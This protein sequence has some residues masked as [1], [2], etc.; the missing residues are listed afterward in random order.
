MT[1]EKY[2]VQFSEWMRWQEYPSHP[3]SKHPGVY[4][5]GRFDSFPPTLSC[6]DENIIYIGE[7]VNQTLKERLYQ[8][9]RSAFRRTLGHSGGR[10]FS[11]KLL[12]GVGQDAPSWL[13]V[14]LFPVTLTE[15]CLSAYI[16]FAERKL[17]WDYVQTWNALPQ[18]NMK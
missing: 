17:I 6:F 4:L 16:R 7:T 18:C 9:G 11:D 15:P 13:Y 2:A 1:G 3:D 14:A 10:T 5:L 8:F 12:G